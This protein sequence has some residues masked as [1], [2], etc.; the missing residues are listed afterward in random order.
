MSKKSS[1]KIKNLLNIA[2]I[3][4][5]IGIFSSSA[6]AQQLDVKEDKNGIY[7]SYVGN[8]LAYQVDTV[9][10]L[11]FATTH[12]GED[13]SITIV[14]CKLLAKRPEWKSIIDWVEINNDDSLYNR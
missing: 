12:F 11:C 5:F 10:Q 7:I 9:S 8:K 14:D 4:G 3:F 6:T 13:A 2:L 1:P